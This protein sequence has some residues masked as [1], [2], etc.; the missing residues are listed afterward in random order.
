MK[1][2]SKCLVTKIVDISLMVRLQSTINH[3]TA[4]CDAYTTR[5]LCILTIF[6]GSVSDPDP[7]YEKKPNFRVPKG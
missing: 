5:I 4:L 6:V 7:G 2:L 3:A 1:E